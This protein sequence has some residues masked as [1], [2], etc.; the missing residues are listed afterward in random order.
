MKKSTNKE[1]YSKEEREIKGEREKERE[2]QRGRTE[3]E[4]KKEVTEGGGKIEEIEI[5]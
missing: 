4:K 3:T 2:R 5:V 1:C